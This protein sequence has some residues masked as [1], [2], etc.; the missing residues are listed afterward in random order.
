VLDEADVPGP[1]VLAGFSNGGLFDLL[2]TSSHPTEVVGLVLIDGVHPEYHTR[3]VEV[4]KRLVPP[5]QWPGIPAAICRIPPVQLDAEQMDICTAEAQTRAALAARPLRPMPLAVL[6]HR[7]AEYPPGTLDAA[8]EALF[9][10]L[11]AEL[12]ALLPGARHVVAPTSDHDI[13]VLHPELVAA[14]I[15]GVVRAVRNGCTTVQQG[16]GDAMLPADRVPC[17]PRGA[18]P[19]DR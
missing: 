6:S 12:A 13:H 8:G 11:Q 9:T 5:E 15:T 1:Y 2:Y 4:V 16:D 14:E 18:T 7:P 19:S 3:L 10:Q 17:D